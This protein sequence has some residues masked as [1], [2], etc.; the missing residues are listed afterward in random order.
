MSIISD[1][2]I[3]ILLSVKFLVCVNGKLDAYEAFPNMLS[4]LFLYLEKVCEYLQYTKPICYAA[5]HSNFMLMVCRFIH[6]FDELNYCST[7]YP[8][9]R[10]AS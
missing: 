5:I 3:L 1:K 9:H 8:D 2:G 4:H 7:F 6:T 10:F